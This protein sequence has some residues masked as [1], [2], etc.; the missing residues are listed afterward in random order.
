V[1]YEHRP[2]RTTGE[3]DNTT[4]TVNPAS[5]HLDERDSRSGEF[6]TRIVDSMLNLSTLSA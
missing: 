5:L 1:L 4:L 3:A 2:G 6:G